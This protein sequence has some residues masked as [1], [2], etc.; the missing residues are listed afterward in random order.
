MLVTSHWRNQRPYLGRLSTKFGLPFWFA[1]PFT[2]LAT[3]L[4]GAIVGVP[5]FRLEGAYL[6]LATPGWPNPCG[7]SSP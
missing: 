5:S 4:V 1:L 7:S 3:G 6:A 2:T